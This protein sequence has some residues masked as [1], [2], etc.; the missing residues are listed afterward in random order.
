MTFDKIYNISEKWAIGIVAD[1]EV[2]YFLDRRYPM[3]DQP[4]QIT[5]G[6]Y[7]IDTILE[8]NN[9]IQLD[10]GVPSWYVNK[11]DIEVVKIRLKQYLNGN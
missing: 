10:L 11:Y 9:G 7:Y 3:N 6:S 8:H 5:S 1:D 2:V 4:F